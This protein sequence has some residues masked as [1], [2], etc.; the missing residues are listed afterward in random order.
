MSQNI[1]STCY[2]GNRASSFLSLF[3]FHFESLFCVLE[4]SVF[5]LSLFIH[6]SNHRHGWQLNLIFTNMLYMWSSA[7]IWD[8]KSNKYRTKKDTKRHLTLTMRRHFFFI[9]R[10]SSKPLWSIGTIRIVCSLIFFELDIDLIDYDRLDKVR[11]ELK[12]NHVLYVLRLSHSMLSHSVM[13]HFHPWNFPTYSQKNSLFIVSVKL[14]N[15]ASLPKRPVWN[16]N[17]YYYRYISVAVL[18]SIDWNRYRKIIQ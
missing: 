5:L 1:L 4:K 10:G 3:I 8:D 14:N 12:S 7:F 13:T 15:M 18:W 9:F 17:L 16:L 6:R 2:T 11:E